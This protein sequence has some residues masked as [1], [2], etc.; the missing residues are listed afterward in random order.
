MSVLAACAFCAMCLPSVCGTQK[1]VSNLLEIEL[2]M[3]MR[4]YMYVGKPGP[5]PVFLSIEPSLQP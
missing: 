2:W 1:R 5:H 4:N 3:I